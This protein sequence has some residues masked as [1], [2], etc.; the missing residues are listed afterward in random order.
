MVTVP[1]TIS[2]IIWVPVCALPSGLWMIASG[3]TRS[4]VADES[5]LTAAFRY[6]RSSRTISSRML[7]LFCFAGGVLACSEPLAL[8]SPEASEERWEVHAAK[9][10]LAIARDRNDLLI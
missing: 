4:A 5:R 7:V 3:A 8:P 9:T 10:E 1:V 6:W 2:W